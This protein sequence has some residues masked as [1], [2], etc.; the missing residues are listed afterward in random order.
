MTSIKILKLFRSKAENIHRNTFQKK[1]Q[2]FFCS[3]WSNF[4]KPEGQFQPKNK[5]F[6]NQISK[7]SN[8]S[9]F[10]GEKL[11]FSQKNPLFT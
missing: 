5:E 4:D 2:K 10:F 7:F 1:H 8:L 9:I 6:F 11:I 3:R